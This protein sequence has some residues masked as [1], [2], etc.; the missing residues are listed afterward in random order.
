MYHIIKKGTFLGNHQHHNHS[1]HHHGHGKSLFW[2]IIVNLVL[3]V[4]QVI[5]GLLSGSLSLIAD[6]LHNFSD[7]G[8][9]IIAYAA[10]R[11]SGLPANNSM[12]FG[13]G[14]AQIL[15]AL[16]NSVTLVLIGF[17]LFYEAIIRFQHPEPIDGWVV[18]IVASV[19]LIVDLVTALLTYAG[20]KASVN[21]KAAFIHNV[22]DAM[23]SVVVII[24]GI[25]VL[26]FSIYWV[27]QIATMFISIFV[28][29][30]SWGLIK[31]CVKTLMQA[32]PDDIDRNEVVRLIS[33]I[34]GVTN[35]HHVHIWAIH[36]KFRSLEAHI[37]VDSD[38]LNQVECVK[39]EIK[40]V[41]KS[42]FQIN[43]STLEIESRNSTCKL[44]N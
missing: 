12:T 9:I 34:K 40:A 33:A 24:S 8:A 4:V 30:H 22:S 16:I 25:L 36:E 14:R 5:G 6:A 31:S 27:D 18:I 10:Q 17:Y 26:N 13:Y 42:T 2:A 15:G 29:F 41:L 7:A 39:K 28:L 21:I 35:I 23:A 37:V 20:S 19:A 11:I 44:T 32:V 43:H 1:H 38:N 3:T